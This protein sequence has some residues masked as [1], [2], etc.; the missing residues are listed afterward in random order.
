MLLL[1]AGL[2][3]APQAAPPVDAAEMRR[4]IHG[5]YALYI[6]ADTMPRPALPLSQALR[7]AEDRCTKSKGACAGMRTVLIQRHDPYSADWSRAEVA[8][9]R[10]GRSRVEAVVRLAGGEP[11]LT[12]VFVREDEGWVVDD[13][14]VPRSGR[15]SASYRQLLAS[16]PQRPR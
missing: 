12:W 10:S 14:E 11:F 16:A 13:F 5:A 3:F 4:L 9:Q 8:F 7:A 15:R 6:G 1:A 2:A